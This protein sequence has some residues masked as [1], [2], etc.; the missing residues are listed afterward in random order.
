MIPTK[1]STGKG[2][3]L[4]QEVWLCVGQPEGVDLV[5]LSDFYLSLAIGQLLNF[6]LHYI[7]FCLINQ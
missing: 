5:V 1:V 4:L 3:S 6:T 7:H 2:W